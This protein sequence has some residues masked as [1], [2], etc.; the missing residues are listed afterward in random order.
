MVY[1]IDVCKILCF[2]LCIKTF[3]IYVYVMC[4]TYFFGYF[5]KHKYPC[6]YRFAFCKLCIGWN[7][8]WVRLVTHDPS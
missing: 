5:K 1:F 7:N 4:F 6:M 8:W 2:T 3:P